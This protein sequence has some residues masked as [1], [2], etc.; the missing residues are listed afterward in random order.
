MSFDINMVVAVFLFVINLYLIIEPVKRLG[1]LNLLVGLVTIIIGVG[2]FISLLA[3]GEALMW[4]DVALIFFGV[5]CI[6][7]A[8][9]IGGGF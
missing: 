8:D 3:V 5:F 7:R 2:M 4:I 9:G 6:Y 1:V